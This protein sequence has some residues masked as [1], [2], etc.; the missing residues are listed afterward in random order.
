MASDLTLVQ[1]MQGWDKVSNWIVKELKKSEGHM[2]NSSLEGIS[3]E[4]EQECDK[5]LSAKIVSVE[6]EG[7]LEK[8]EE[9]IKN[10]DPSE[11]CLISDGNTLD[12]M[13]PLTEDTMRWN[14]DVVLVGKGYQGYLNQVRIYY[15]F[16]CK[17]KITEFSYAGYD[18]D[19]N[20]EDEDY[21]D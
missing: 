14:A 7:D 4:Y 8:I 21:D 16:V 6:V 12:D 2:M 1:K 3:E 13:E 5:I 20:D 17:G 11:Y 15:T 19:Y 10:F 9:I 18:N